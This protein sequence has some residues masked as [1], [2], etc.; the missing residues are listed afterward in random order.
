MSMILIVSDDSV[1]LAQIL[2][3]I[4]SLGHN[5]ETLSEV[6]H[7]F[8]LLE[9]FSVELLLLDLKTPDLE[10]T[11]LLIQLQQ[12]SKHQPIPTL[13][14]NF[15]EDFQLLEWSMTL[16]FVDFISTGC[17]ANLLKAK[18]HAALAARERELQLKTEIEL[19]QYAVKHIEHQS[20]LLQSVSDAII[21]VDL[22]FNISSWNKAAE[23]V[24]GWEAEEVLSKPLGAFLLL[25]D[26]TRFRESIFDHVL[27]VG[28]WTGEMKHQHR[29]GNTLVMMISINVIREDNGTP[30]GFVSVNRDITEMKV[31]EQKQSYLE[32][33][34]Q[35]AHKMKIMRTFAEGVAHD[36]N[37]IL[38][39]ILGYAQLLREFLPEKTDER[40]YI[41][42]IVQ[43]GARAKNVVTQLRDFAALHGKELA[44][45]TVCNAVGQAVT[46]LK[47]IFPDTIEIRV[48]PHPDCPL[49]LAEESQIYQAILNIGINAKDAMPE[50]GVFE[51][52]ITDAPFS[53]ISE[54][55]SPGSPDTRFLVITL[56]D[57]G[58]GMSYE[59]KERLFEPFF[60]TKKFREQ[61]VGI[62][63]DGIGLGLSI[64]YNIVERHKGIITVDSDLG[65][66]STFSLYFPVVNTEM[67]KISQESSLES[68]PSKSHYR[69]LLAEDD[70]EV[71]RYFLLALQREGYEVTYCSDGKTALQRFKKNPQRYDLVI[72]DQVMPKMRGLALSQELIKLRRD[73]PILLITG[74]SQTIVTN[75]FQEFGIRKLLMKPIYL[76]EL[77]QAVKELLTETK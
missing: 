21:S 50:G 19:Q 6:Q 4:E 3:S 12:R 68:T 51:I 30:V 46:K 53:N 25:E 67:L 14:L 32:K 59:V 57:S 48:T 55:L 35:Y 41:E 60:T 56:K 77:I 42:N 73:L 13:L 72:T 58:K 38:S 7:L 26:Q 27:S 15:E 2:P 65:K 33:Q 37:N 9:E 16:D 54:L 52:M 11:S 63:Q 24:Y 44:P 8:Q 34:M 70:S 64:V 36:I 10:I 5:A 75:L 29:K 76:G 45:M 69:I 39:I 74:Y 31:A 23:K 1:L 17:N 22:R 43:S 66:G 49:I 28:Q 20:V 71:G 61:D 47:S 62:S 40:R 18:I